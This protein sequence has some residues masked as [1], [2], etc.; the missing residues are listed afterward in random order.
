MFHKKSIKWRNRN[1]HNHTS[2]GNNSFP[3]DSV[4]VGN[5]TYGELNVWLYSNDKREQLSIGSCCSIA[6]GVDFLLGGGHKMDTLS[7]FPIYRYL[8]DKSYEEATT[9]GAIVVEDD[10]WIGSGVL[11]LSGV[12]IGKGTVVAAGSVVTSSTEPYSIVG[13]VPAKLIKKRFD[14]DTIE[15][16]RNIDFTKLSSSYVEKN[17]NLFHKSLTDFTK[18]DWALIDDNL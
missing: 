15:R 5:Y 7:T 2:I 16:L 4:S 17:R 13:G 8:V 3:L 18:N 9:K 1:K 6:R 10:V 14:D 11:I 12:K